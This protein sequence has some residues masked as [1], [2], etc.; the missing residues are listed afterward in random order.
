MR[1]LRAW[2]VRPTSLFRGGRRERE[3]AE[4]LESHFQLH[5]DDNILA[6]MSSAEARRAA[7]LRFGPV[8]SIEEA[9]RGCAG[10]PAIEIVLQDL[11]YAARRIRRQPLFALLIVLTLALGVGANA[12][13]FGLVDAVMFRTPDHVRD[14]QGLVEVDAGTYIKYRELSEQLRSVDLAVHTNP[15]TLSLGWRETSRHAGSAHFRERRTCDPRIELAERCRQAPEVVRRTCRA[16]V[17]VQRGHR[18]AVQHR[19]EAA[20]E[21]VLHTVAVEAGEQSIRIPPGHVTRR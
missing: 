16:D 13:M 11:R 2:L 21:D 1:T 10:I 14:P 19:G 5:I 18:R 20:D 17:C 6:G 15:V 7:I 3:M 12:A 8:E 4:E 9:Y